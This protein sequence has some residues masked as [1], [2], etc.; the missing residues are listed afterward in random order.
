MESRLEMEVAEK[1][2]FGFLA[3]SLSLGIA[4]NLIVGA[5]DQF[6][7]H[8]EPKYSQRIFVLISRIFVVDYRMVILGICCHDYF[9]IFH[10]IQSLDGIQMIE[11]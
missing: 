11:I 10:F 1:L 5:H 2:F 9:Q 4:I 7:G 3:F 6:G 8:S